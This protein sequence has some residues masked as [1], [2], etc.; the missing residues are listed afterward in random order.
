MKTVSGLLRELTGL[1]SEEA[2]RFLK[3]WLDTVKSWNS[4]RNATPDG[5]LRQMRDLW[6]Y[7][8]AIAEG[9]VEQLESEL[10]RHV[11][12]PSEIK[13]GLPASAAEAQAVLGLPA[14]GAAERVAALVCVEFDL[15]V[16]LV[17]RGST[18]GTR[19]AIYSR[20]QN[21]TSEAKYLA[22]AEQL[23]L[24][25]MEQPGG[26]FIAYVPAYLVHPIPSPQPRVK[27]W[28]DQHQPSTIQWPPQNGVVCYMV[29]VELLDPPS[30]ATPEQSASPTAPQS[31]DGPDR[32]PGA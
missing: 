18:P 24:S 13:Y 16:K 11:V 28:V 25:T 1:T 12:P 7:I 22:I 30:R 4:G 29:P 20:M 19:K 31:Q 9:A 15:N 10:S 27:S 23:G 32:R 17:R 3:V 26:G 2:A 5:V 8:S 14:V 21:D 6:E